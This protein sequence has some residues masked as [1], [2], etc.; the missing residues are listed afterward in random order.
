VDILEI[1]NGIE[2][3]FVAIVQAMVGSESNNIKAYYTPTHVAIAKQIAKRENI[4]GKPSCL[5]YRHRPQDTTKF[6]RNRRQFL[7]DY[8]GMAFKLFNPFP[9]PV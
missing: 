5:Y 1:H 9:Q 2:E 7:I 6:L 8:P 3:G 4:V